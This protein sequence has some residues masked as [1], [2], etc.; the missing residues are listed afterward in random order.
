MARRRYCGWSQAA[1]ST[2]SSLSRDRPR[3]AEEGAGR[4]I[5][6]ESVGGASRGGF[7]A[8]IKLQQA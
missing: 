2:G 5:A 4:P 7:T 6:P 3:G 1:G 8:Q